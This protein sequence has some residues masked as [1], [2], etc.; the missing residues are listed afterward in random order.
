MIKLKNIVDAIG[1]EKFSEI[2]QYEIEKI[3][4]NFLPLQQGLSQSSYVGSAPVK[5]IILNIAKEN[6]IKI[7]TGVF[8]SGIIAGCNC[9]DDPSP[10]DEQTEYCELLFTIHPDTADTSVKLLSE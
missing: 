2:A 8:Y 7:K 10:V 4:P 9:S 5:V 3:D 1:S 6:E